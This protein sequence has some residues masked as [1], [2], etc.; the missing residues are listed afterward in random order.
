MNGFP[1]SNAAATNAAFVGGEQPDALA[2]WGT[3]GDD[4]PQTCW[5]HEVIDDTSSGWPGRCDE[6]TKVSDSNDQAACS[7]SCVDQPLC[8]SWAVRDGSCFHGIGD[9]CFSAQPSPVAAQRIMHGKVRVLMNLPLIQIYSLRTKFP[10]G[11]F[12]N[13]STAITECA[14]VCYSNILCQYWIFSEAHGCLVEEPQRHSTVQY[15]LTQS[16]LSRTSAFA[17]SVVAGEYIQH[18][19][20]T[21]GVVPAVAP[22]V[23][24]AF[25][26]GASPSSAL[27]RGTTRGAGLLGSGSAALLAMGSL[28][29]LALLA[30]ARLLSRQRA[31]GVE[32]RPEEMELMCSRHAEED[33]AQPL[34]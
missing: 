13:Q 24:Q 33:D 1:G 9:S 18:Y 23:Q 15:P 8:A 25:E 2:C 28:G 10:A 27:R 34:E 22:A 21:P 17:H 4:T 16:G 30:S 31:S 12:V 20:P 29:A 32:E 3:L 6:M 11:F 7:L 5:Y 19:C 26:L 14:K